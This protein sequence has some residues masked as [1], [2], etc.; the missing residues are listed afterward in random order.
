MYLLNT[1]SKEPNKLIHTIISHKIDWL[2][3]FPI[4]HDI[5]KLEIDPI[6]PWLYAL[7]LLSQT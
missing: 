4:V 3:V 7:F 6:N 1:I 2:N 5:C